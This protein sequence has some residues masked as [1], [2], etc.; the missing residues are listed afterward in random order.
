MNTTNHPPSILHLHPVFPPRLLHV[1]RV[2]Y[3]SQICLSALPAASVSLC[4]ETRLTP[5]SA[6]GVDPPWRRLRGSTPLRP[7]QLVARS[8]NLNSAG[9]SRV[10][11]PHQNPTF[12]GTPAQTLL[13]ARETFSP[14]KKL[15]VRRRLPT[16]ASLRLFRFFHCLLTLANISVH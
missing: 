10:T 13:P 3:G 7:P 8:R 1:L 14:Q 2:L 5:S 4:P 16:S 11:I 6:P 15:F 12:Y 9:N